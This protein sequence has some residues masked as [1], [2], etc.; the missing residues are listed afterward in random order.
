MPVPIAHA[1]PTAVPSDVVVG[2]RCEVLDEMA[3]LGTIRFVGETSF[4]KGGV[5]VGLELDEPLGKGDG[6]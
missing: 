3:R 6:R 2:A 5:W 4:G 1:P